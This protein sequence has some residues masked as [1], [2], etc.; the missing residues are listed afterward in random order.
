[1]NKKRPTSIY[2]E[3]FGFNTDP[4][5]ITPDP[6]YFFESRRHA[7]TLARIMY[8]VEQRE[9]ALIL[10]DVGTG[11]TLLSRCLVDA[12]PEEQ[13]RLAWIINPI[14]TPLTFLKE[15]HRQLF[16]KE[17]GPYRRDVQEAV[18][19]G[20]TELYLQNIHP[21]VIIDEAQEIPKK[22]VFDEIRLLSNFQTDK[23]NLMSIVFFGQLELRRRLKHPGY[24]SL[25]ERIRFSITLQPFDETETREYILHR[26]K[27]AGNDSK[28]LFDADALSVI[29][30]LTA[31]YPRRINHLA[32]FALMEA[33]GRDSSMVT[34]DIVETAAQDILY[35]Q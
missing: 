10:G 11:K 7:E 20:L 31:G 1:M 34:P 6:Q 22:G 21:V 4:F 13:Y 16:S 25:L 29:F 30:R 27:I 33:M 14:L 26:L 24:R 18:R 12:L 32:S 2:C 19:E 35:L 5:G 8:A 23:E 28:M 17:A 3:Y 15:I 9:M